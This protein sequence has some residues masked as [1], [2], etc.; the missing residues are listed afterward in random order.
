M[1]NFI[2]IDNNLSL[3]KLD[4]SNLKDIWLAK[5]LDQDEVIAGKNGFLYSIERV[6]QGKYYLTK[7]DL[8]GTPYA[9]Y[10]DK[11]IP[12]GF[13]EIGTIINDYSV[14]LTYALIKEARGKGYMCNTLKKTSNLI[15][16]DKVNQIENIRLVIDQKNIASEKTALRAGFNCIEKTPNK[17]NI[18]QLTKKRS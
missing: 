7:K 8:Y 6:L 17:Y 1:E 9:I 14:F 12:I 2:V 18:Y 13:L 5:T 11:K 10:Q 3:K 4:P 16:S 15:F